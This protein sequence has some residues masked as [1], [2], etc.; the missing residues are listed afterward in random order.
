MAVSKGNTELIVPCCRTSNPTSATRA[1]GHH[2]HIGGG[3]CHAACSVA[4]K[5]SVC[6]GVTD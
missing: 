2:S 5:C 3:P 4:F 1:G 6:S